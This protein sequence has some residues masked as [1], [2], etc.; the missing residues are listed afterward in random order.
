[1][2]FA[3]AWKSY[4]TTPACRLAAYIPT[5][6]T[7]SLTTAPKQLSVGSG[8]SSPFPA[9]ARLDPPPHVPSPM[10]FCDC[11]NRRGNPFLAIVLYGDD[12]MPYTQRTQDDD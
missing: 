6:C 1:M 9:C 5:P 11:A 8:R 3:F 7:G 12:N 10:I 4:S 2:P